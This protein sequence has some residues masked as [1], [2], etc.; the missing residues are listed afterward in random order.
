MAATTAHTADVA[1]L[2]DGVVGAAITHHLAARGARV[3]LVAPGRA[4]PHGATRRTAAQVR[5]HHGDPDAARLAALSLPTWREWPRAVGG[6]CGFRRTGFA[7][8]CGPDEVPALHRSVAELTGLGVETAV[9]D[10]AEFA[11]GQPAL[12]LRGVAAVAVEPQGGYADPALARDGYL[13]RARDR[14]ARL[15]TAEGGAALVRRGE[16]G[17]RVVAGSAEVSAG[18]VVLAAGAWS[19]AVLAG[20]RGTGRAGAPG[21][22]ADRGAAALAAALRARRYG[23]ALADTPVADALCMVIDGVAG[24]YFRP[25][26]GGRVLFRVPLPSATAATPPAHDPGTAVTAPEVA[27]GRELAARRLP[28]LAAAPVTA[29]TAGWESCSADGRPLIGPAPGLPGLY[30][31]TGFSGGGFKTAPAVGRAVAAELL[32]GAERAELAPYRP[33]RFVTG[34]PRPVSPRYRHL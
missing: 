10:P 2:G 33:E 27:A 11:A 30:L 25:H 8:L 12:D 7:F 26:G 1:V 22:G 15:V 3:T 21:G 16:R 20:L 5:M 24:T 18:H 17:V 9:L 28:G 13:R 31:A 14:G 6:D 23:W 19:G 34:S 29:A 32:S 4:H